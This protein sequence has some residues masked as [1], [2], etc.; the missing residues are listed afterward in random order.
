MYRVGGTKAGPERTMPQLQEPKKKRTKRMKKM[1]RRG[2]R[3]TA[4][5]REL[6]MQASAAVTSTRG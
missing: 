3:I 2:G 6:D 4:P 1:K 5:P